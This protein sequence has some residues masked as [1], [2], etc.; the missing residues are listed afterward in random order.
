MVPQLSLLLLLLSACGNKKADETKDPLKVY[1]QN[2]RG[3]AEAAPA[4]ELGPDPKEQSYSDAIAHI[5]D[6]PS[7]MPEETGEQE[8]FKFT[9][10]F[11]KLTNVEAKTVFLD[12]MET[13]SEEE[14]TT[15]MREAMAKA[16][17]ESCEVISAWTPSTADTP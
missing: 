14:R 2:Q 7:A 3:M 12:L 8:E 5:C 10:W 6:I 17:L 9:N 1:S 13:E 4:V 15:K 16:G 11:G